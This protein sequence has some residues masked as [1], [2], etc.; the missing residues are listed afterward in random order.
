M[1]LLILG[2]TQFVGR[3]VTEQA[4]ARGHRVTLFHRG[5]TNPGLF[6]EADHRHGDRLESLDA[7]SEGIWDAVLDVS[8]YVPRAVRMA[9]DAL[10]GRIGTYAFISTIS[11]YDYEQ[12]SPIRED[13][14]Q[15][16]LED[17]FTEE[18]TAKSYGGLKVRCEQALWGL[19]Q[20]PNLV[21]RPGLIIGPH[22]ST[23]RFT[24]WPWRM[25]SGGDILIPDTRQRIQWIDVR[26]LAEWTLNMLES[27]AQGTFNAIGPSSATTLPEM[28]VQTHEA[29]GNPGRLVPVSEDRL[30]EAG[31][32]GADL[33]FWMAGAPRG[34]LMDVD[35]AS[36]SARGL[37]F[38]P[39]AESVHDL[40]AQWN[41]DRP[42]ERPKNGL[43]AEREA[44]LLQVQLP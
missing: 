37:R 15:L 40:L 28:L 13:G 44:E 38:R 8:A 4:L 19:H 12:P 43:S 42:G 5:K 33:P 17:P 41:A 35:F 14:V 22:D 3:T 27:G 11:V 29:L 30:I 21:I 36:A 26:D 20:G 23:E 6:P 10:R 32:T 24:Y 25:A 39:L 18:I 34:S 7:L 1:N 16:G 9:V 2:G 31:L